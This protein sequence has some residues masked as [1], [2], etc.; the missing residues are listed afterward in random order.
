MEEESLLEEVNIIHEEISSKR[1]LP[2]R[3]KTAAC[4]REMGNWWL[5]L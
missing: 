2:H 1:H 3:R 4:W 5:D